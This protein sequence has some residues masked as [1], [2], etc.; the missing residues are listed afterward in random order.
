[1]HAVYDGAFTLSVVGPI[2]S[3]SAS[4]SISSVT[5][6]NGKIA[7]VPSL[8]SLDTVTA[9]IGGSGAPSSSYGGQATGLTPSFHFNRL[10]VALPFSSASSSA[11]LATQTLT[12]AVLNMYTGILSLSFALTGQST[13]TPS[14]P[15]RLGTITTD[16]YPVAQLPFCAMQTFSLSLQPAAYDA[17][18][19]GSTTAGFVSHEV[20]APS[21]TASGGVSSELMGPIYNTTTRYVSPRQGSSSTPS[22]LA[23][24]TALATYDGGQALASKTV[25]AACAYLLDVPTNYA[26]YGGGASQ[27][28]RS[29]AS[30]RIALLTSSVTGLLPGVFKFS[31]LTAVM[32]TDDFPNPLEEC[33]RLLIAIVSSSSSQQTATDAIRAGHV[34]VWANNWATCITLNPKTQATDA[35]KQQL[36]RFQRVARYSLFQVFASTR[37]GT[38][39]SLDP[40]SLGL[41]ALTTVTLLFSGDVFL[42]PVLLITRPAAAKS[43]LA[44]RAATLDVAMRLAAGFGLAGAQYPSTAVQA[45]VLG[46]YRTPFFYGTPVTSLALYNSCLVS[47]SVWNYFRVTHDIDW[48]ITTGYPIL[49]SVA[50]M[51]ASAATID[52]T[53]SGAYHLVGVVGLSGASLSASDSQED[54]SFTVYFTR[55]ALTYA[56]Q[57]AFE[58]R[59]E[60][61]QAWFDVRAGLSVSTFSSPSDTS[62]TIASTNV[63]LLNVIMPNAGTAV[64]ATAPTLLDFLV[65]L[66]PF[67]AVR[68][69]AGESCSSCLAG[70][71]ADVAT[72]NLAYWTTHLAPG[73]AS[74]PFNQLVTAGILINKAQ[75]SA[76]PR[77]DAE[78]FVA[79]LD[80]FLNANM[81]SVWGNLL[82]PTASAT[83]DDVTQGGA[84]ATSNDLGVAGAYLFVLL[85][86][87]AGIT[88][89]GTVSP[90]RGHPEPVRINTTRR[91]G[92][93]PHVWLNMSVT[94]VGPSA[95]LAS[96]VTNRETY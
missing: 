37:A 9:R 63:E 75:T 62:L 20:Y 69:L 44:Y 14:T 10:R 58:I 57:A 72:R 45:D 36:A 1:M 80:A 54:D 51:L 96:L 24:L 38:A 71:S 79:T 22:G 92:V 5:L 18:P 39:V 89:Q 34:G 67:Y 61:S 78:A 11:A 48:L 94:G 91:S 16:I 95:G 55:L 86:C 12:S 90:T 50:D 84:V 65:P 26:Q 13:T 88:I 52:A 2:A 29:Q 81:D 70:T 41:A 23:M 27:Q 66:L 74:L 46:S 17:M 59:R 82:A 15:V 19:S 6:G 28:D 35:E 31:V 64:G 21:G 68:P 76:T 60:A 87:A 30:D 8:S 3:V 93:L 33:I 73:T 85:T 42:L 43:M 49:R 7:L 77:D 25:A 47:T 56:I 32:T 53:G 83:L 40:S 4:G